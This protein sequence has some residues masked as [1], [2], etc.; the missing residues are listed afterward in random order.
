M[1]TNLEGLLTKR[2]ITQETYDWLKPLHDQENADLEEIKRAALE[3]KNNPFYWRDSDEESDSDDDLTTTTTTTLNGIEGTTTRISFVTDNNSSGHGNKVWH[4]S[5]ATCRYL[6]YHFRPLLLSG[7][8]NLIDND[9]DNDNDN[10]TVRC[11]ELGAGTAVPSFFLAQLLRNA[12]IP[13]SPK[14]VVLRITDAK[15]YR[16]IMQILRSIEIQES[17]LDDSLL[18]QVHPHKWGEPIAFGKI[19]NDDNVSPHDLVIVSDCI[20]D[21]SYHNDLLVSLSRTLR[22]PFK[23]TSNGG[24][25]VVSFSLHGNVQDSAIWEFLESKL[26]STI[27][28]DDTGTGWRLEARCVSSNEET[29]EKGWHM[30]TTMNELGMVTEGIEPERWLAY[31]YEITW[32][33]IE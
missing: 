21:P 29:G 12:N 19:E 18:I 5:I 31:V 22:L 24:I 28:K 8:R 13:S 7:E 3:R 25:A 14:H 26:P 1:N 17:L 32:V 6:K 16:N 2:V 30:E 23:T 15:Y 33:P 9:N 4:A 11:L 20:Y 10:N 27:R